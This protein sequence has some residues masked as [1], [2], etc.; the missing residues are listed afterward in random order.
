MQYD[1]GPSY[2]SKFLTASASVF[3]I[4]IDD[5]IQWLPGTTTVWHPQNV[6]SVRSRGAELFVSGRK[7]WQNWGFSAGATYGYT[8]SQN[9]KTGKQLIYVPHHRATF[10]AG[11][12]RGRFSALWTASYTGEVFTRTDNNPRYNIDP[13]VVCNMLASVKIGKSKRVSAS[14]SVRNLFNVNYEVVENRPFPGRHYLINL[15]LI[16]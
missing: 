6:S 7:S 3:L 15:N 13:Y 14:L 2:K 4:D 11:A 10:S 5:M 12:A 16:L 8:D 9:R 1:F